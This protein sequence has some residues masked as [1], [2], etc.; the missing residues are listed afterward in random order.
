MSGSTRKA[1]EEHPNAPD[2]QRYR[3]EQ[4]TG[5]R[6]NLVEVLEGAATGGK[7]NNEGSRTAKIL[8]EQTNMLQEMQFQNKLLVETLQKM[9][10]EI[11]R[12]VPQER[13][14]EEI[15]MAQ[16]MATEA[17]DEEA[18]L[19]ETLEKKCHRITKKHCTIYW[20]RS[21]KRPQIIKKP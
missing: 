13:G 1:N 15:R 7:G 10:E 17:K 8:L 12:G 16:P 9:Q 18:W 14:A 4:A 19:A 5:S 21:K 3:Q 20:E 2:I 6:S 11:R